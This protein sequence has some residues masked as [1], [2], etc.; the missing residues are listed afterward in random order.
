MNF[1]GLEMQKWNILAEGAQRVDEQNSFIFLILFTARVIVIKMSKM[2]HFCIFFWGQQKSFQ[3]LVAHLNAR[4]R[5]FWV[6]SEN[7]IQ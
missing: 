5:S 7:G 3:R 2:T 4:K 1:Q 6:L